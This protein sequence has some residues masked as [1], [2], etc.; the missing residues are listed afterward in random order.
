[1]KKERTKKLSLPVLLLLLILIAS[2]AS[3]LYWG[4]RKEGY[5]VDEM[6]MYGT[7]NSEYLPFMH[8]GCQEYSVKDWMRDYGAGDNIAQLFRNLAKD[9]RILKGNNWD[10]KGSV[11]YSDYL[12]AQACSNDMY[13][14]GWMTGQDYTYYL[15]PAPENRFNFISVLYNFRGDNHPPL[16]ALLLHF[17]C[18][19][20]I[21]KHL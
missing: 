16:Y 8:L 4:S 21:R 5:H 18:S 9:F 19:F 20:F 15:S 2:L 6:Y 3:S 11:I 1:M 13:S 10:I 12:R 14:T 17:V 7:A